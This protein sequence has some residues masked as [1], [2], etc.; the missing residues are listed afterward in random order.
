MKKLLA[1]LVVAVLPL[2]LV[3]CGEDEDKGPSKADYIKEA[4]AICARSNQET[5]AIFEEAVENPRKPKPDEAQAAIEQAV[6]VLDKDIKELKALEPPKD[7]KDQVAAIWS[8]LEEGVTTLEEASADP[9]ASLV[10][11]VNDPFAAGEK[12]ADEYGM[13]ACGSNNE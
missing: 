8:A 3:A 7:D 13:K 6:P 1:T 12:L 2:G 11:L 4:D 10:A 5:D 9:E